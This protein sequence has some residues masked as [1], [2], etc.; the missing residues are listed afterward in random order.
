MKVSELLAD[1][2]NRPQN[3]QIH[4]IEKDFEVG[5]GNLFVIESAVK[6]DCDG[7]VILMCK[8]VTRKP[9]DMAFSRM[10][11][12]LERGKPTR[13]FKTTI[14]ESVLNPGKYEACIDGRS[15]G[16][17][18]TM[19]ETK[20]FLRGFVLGSEMGTSGKG[21]ATKYNLSPIEPL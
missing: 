7:V 1:L 16:L 9:I 21:L 14:S 5:P 18:N 2:T 12:D 15:L 17:F 20:L 19:E 10:L 8:S 4:L 11:E 13:V 6:E 3:A